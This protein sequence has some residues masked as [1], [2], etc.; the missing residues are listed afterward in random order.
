[1]PADL[2]YL[3]NVI[4]TNM[5]GQ[6]AGL[7]NLPAQMDRLTNMPADLA[8]LTNAITTNMAGQLA[9]LTNL[10]AQVATLTGMPVR[11]ATL[12]NLPAQM[13]TLTNMPS[14]MITLSNAW[15]SLQQRIGTDLDPVSTNTVFGRLA[16]LVEQLGGVGGAANNAATIARSAKTQAST[17]AGAASAVRTQLEKAQFSRML[18]ALDQMRTAL[19]ATLQQVK[20]IPDAMSTENLVKSLRDTMGKIDEIA[21]QR[22]VDLGQ[23][24]DVA[25]GSF[26]DPKAVA[27]L[28]NTISE[29]KAM[30]EAMRLLMDEAVNKPVVVDWLESPQ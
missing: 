7:T 6:L 1:M 4:T 14:Q 24:T 5:A 10:P 12:T 17:A 19:D 13:V 29:T 3:T 8:Y 16:L 27:K 11:L 26:S 28:L 23:P 2:A 20:G 30:M 18:G 25:P 21:K 22:G 9:G 15:A